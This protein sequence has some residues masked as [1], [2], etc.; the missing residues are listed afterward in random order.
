MRAVRYALV[1]VLPV[2][3]AVLL[4]AVTYDL[5]LEVARD[6]A[7]WL[8]RALSDDEAVRA[9]AYAE[10][11]NGERTRATNWLTFLSAA[12]IIVGAML[13]S[14]VVPSR[15]TRGDGVNL[16]VGLACG[17]CAAKVLGGFSDLEWPAFG[18]WLI[19]G[20]ICALAS[21]QVRHLLQGA[22]SIR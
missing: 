2:C 1:F 15:A 10:I 7:E 4:H 14:F 16:L 8:T 3:I 19:A 9:G 21:I 6:S 5:H 22:S 20:L 18:A 13:I 12:S 17:F 11:A